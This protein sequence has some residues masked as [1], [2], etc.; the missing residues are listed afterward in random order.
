M[1]GLT[2]R[3]WT[4][5]EIVF[6]SKELVDLA[7]SQLAADILTRRKITDQKQVA[8]Y[9][10][11]KEYTPSPS[12]DLPGME[13]AVGKILRS[14]HNG[15]EICVWGDFDVD[16]QTSTTI[17]VSTLQQ[18]GAKVRHYIPLRE[19]ES[20]GIH[21]E[22]L[23][24]LA[25]DGV[26]LLITCDTGISAVKEVDWAKS[27]K[28]DVVITDHHELPEALPKADAIINPRLLPSDHPLYPL[29]GCGVAFKLAEELLTRS[30]KAGFAQSLLDLTALGIV[31]DA[32]VLKGECRYLLQLGLETLRSSSRVGLRQLY[33]AA[34][35]DPALIN[36]ETISY[37]IAP[38]MNA[39]GRLGDAN[40][41]V[42]FLT[43]TSNSQAA[44]FTKRLEDFNNK[45]ILECDRVFQDA[46]A[47]TEKRPE[48]LKYAA[49]VLEGSDWKAGVVGIAA[50]RL[51][52]RF[53]RPVILF[54]V[55]PDGLARGSARSLEG[56]NITHAIAGL[57]DML[58]GFGG[59]PMAAGLSLPADLIP[60][61]RQA[62]SYIVQ[63]QLGESQE[64]PPLCLD[65]E[66]PLVKA[67]LLTAD[68]LSPLS[69]FGIGNPQ[70]VFFST[71][72]NM[73]KQDPIGLNGEHLSIRVEDQHGQKYDLL[74]WNG[75]GMLLP[76]QSDSFDLAY[77]LRAST[78]RGERQLQLEWID[79]R[80]TQE[81]IGLPSR[82]SE[83]ELDDQRGSDLTAAKVVALSLPDSV[84]WNEG[85]TEKPGEDR[86]GL[87]SAETLVI[88]F[89]PPGPDEIRSVMNRVSPT[90]VM[91]L[92][93]TLPNDDPG[94]FMQNLMKILR[95][96]LEENNPSIELDQ[97]AARLGHRGRTV[98][99]GLQYLQA[100]GKLAVMKDAKG[101]MRLSRQA[102]P[103]IDLARK[104]VIEGNLRI[105]L[106]ETSAFRSY[107]LA[108]D[109]E[110]LEQDFFKQ[111]H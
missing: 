80:I 23:K 11:P 84:F 78:F 111:K 77:S 33:E 102:A 96:Y 92:P 16:G 42:D 37:S 64:I 41:I 82:T 39:L 56:V 29:P 97:L 76:E 98:E 103:E 104:P 63:R 87:H 73:I 15:E 5:P 24:P 69:P 91:L 28:M 71:G 61:F 7:G 100:D 57:K 72:H 93:S 25:A 85:S 38:R 70:P 8:A 74:Y 67:D 86:T 68:Q 50:S 101:K 95:P 106:T 47:L 108:A 20:H 55:S 44:Y 12:C 59:H 4:I 83:I 48:L 9:L 81:S 107:Y 19:K 99:L 10:S 1:T 36:E 52:E 31:A 90:R 34:K 27:N 22:S 51:V 105:A 21:L 58:S 60:D 88:A 40:G 6:P 65:A 32:A 46:I 35:V 66:I 30:G 43:T 45:R 13:E 49:L 54:S 89:P 110:Q 17:L 53:H 26:R 2:E 18:L 14:I 3:A 109:G 75:K 62:L 79:F 94:Y